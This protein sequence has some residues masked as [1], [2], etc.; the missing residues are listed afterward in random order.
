[1]YDGEGYI[2]TDDGLR[3]YFHAVG[4]GPQ[5]V[6]VPA[7]CWLDRDFDA[8]VEG[9]TLIFYDERGRGGSDAITD[10][11]QLAAGYEERD[12]EAARAY[13]GLE[14]MA[15]IGWSANGGT[16]A[17]YAIKH[18]QHVERMVLMCP[19]APYGDA[20]FRYRNPPESLEKA[21]ARMNP[22]AVQRLE[23]L[24]AQGMAHTDPEGYCRE[25]IEVYTPR[26]MGNPAALARMKSDPCRFP[27]EW[28]ANFIQ[29]IQL[30]PSPV[31]WD[32]RPQLATLNVPTLVVH[33]LEDLILL[34]TSREWAA[35]LPDA[36]LLTIEGS[37]HY[38]HM[39]AP[40]VIFPAVSSFL[41]G[42]WPENAECIRKG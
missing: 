18:P 14:K 19:V 20:G 27:N 2:S 11:S 32:W 8:I 6:V 28:I 41:N 22:D 4:D 36:R 1:M 35:V 38:P 7:G 5:N 23:E 42:T 26:Q 15:L 37:G 40:E 24:R 25:T 29:F 10:T 3:L 17:N 31:A 13:F 16:V 30:Q 33:G 34:E 9:R 39:E 21:E 12:L